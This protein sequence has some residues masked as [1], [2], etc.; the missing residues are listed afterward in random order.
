MSPSPENA[1]PVLVDD[2]E[3]AAP[4]GLGE[5]ADE[6]PEPVADSCLLPGVPFGLV[7][8]VDDPGPALDV[9]ERQESPV[10]AIG[11]VVAIVP[12]GEALAGGDDDR[13]EVV[14]NQVVVP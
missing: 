6:F 2:F 14:A 4:T 8:E 10:A 12:H 5:K 1:I 9:V 11:A 7:G 3:H 13:A